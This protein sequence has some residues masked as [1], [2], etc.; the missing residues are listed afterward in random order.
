MTYDEI[1][2]IG[3]GFADVEDTLAWGTPGLKR[4]KRFML[5]LKEDGE[6]I[7]VKVSWDVHD[8]LL[9]DKPEIFFKTPHYDGYPAVLARL[10]MLDHPEAKA[11]VEA[12]WRDAPMPAKTKP[13]S[14]N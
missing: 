12:S 13:A 3:L 11:L 4:K 6:T 7:A 9:A 14:N 1:V 8:R 10:D 2:E 5:R